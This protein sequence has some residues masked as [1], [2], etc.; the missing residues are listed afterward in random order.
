MLHVVYAVAQHVSV[1][2]IPL[3]G[4]RLRL[5]NGELKLP[6]GGLA[7]LVEVD[8]DHPDSLSLLGRKVRLTGRMVLRRDVHTATGRLGFSFPHA[9]RQVETS[10]AIAFTRTTVLKN[11]T[12]FPEARE[13]EFVVLRSESDPWNQ[14]LDER[15]MEYREPGTITL[16]ELVDMLGG[17]EP[18]EPVQFTS[19]GGITE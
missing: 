19:E 3:A 2:N 18:V 15:M 10:L 12:A 14:L 11:F 17:P 9:G 8:C 13:V 7:L 1:K 5:P 16:A 6:Y 4:L